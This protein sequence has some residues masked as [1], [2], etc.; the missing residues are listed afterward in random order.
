MKHQELL[1]KIIPELRG[2]NSITAVMLMGSVAAETENPNSDLNLFI[3]GNKN[4]LQSEVIDGI[5]VDYLYVTQEAAQS[6]LDKSGT[7]VYHYMGSKIIYDLDGRLIKLMRSAIN[8]YKKYKANEK[9]KLELRHWLY[10]AKSKLNA[11]INQQESLMSEFITASATDKVIEAVFAINDIPL[12]PISRMF[13]ELP[14]LRHI[15]EPDWFENL[16]NKNTGRRTETI[17]K[18]I[19]WALD[20]L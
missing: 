18:T 1:K 2:D 19:D 13:Y 14:N 10:S 6:K 12:P 20:L 3:L 8:K 15:P 7:E 17:F 5:M 4:K 16:Y 11:S 9:D